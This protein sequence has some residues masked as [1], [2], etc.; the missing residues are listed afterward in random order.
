MSDRYSQ[1][2]FKKINE[3]QKTN[4]Y[5]NGWAQIK[6]RGRQNHSA[7]L[8]V[9]KWDPNFSFKMLLST[10]NKSEKD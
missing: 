7:R 10:K 1:A 5:S 9:V 6:K 8:K 4:L 3:I 2:T